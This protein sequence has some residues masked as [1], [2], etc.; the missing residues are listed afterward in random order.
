MKALTRILLTLMVLAL[1]GPA[2]MAHDD[3]DHDHDHDHG[4][5]H[6]DIWPSFHV[7]EGEFEIGGASL[8]ESVTPSVIELHPHV[9][10]FMA[11]LDDAGGFGDS[12]APGLLAPENG[13]PDYPE[14]YLPPGGTL[15]VKWVAP[16][17]EWNETTEAFDTQAGE[18]MYMTVDSVNL[19]V[20]PSS[21]GT[22]VEGVEFTID[23]HGDIHG[24]PDYRLFNGTT[25]SPSAPDDGIYLTQMIIELDDAVGGVFDSEVIYTVYALN[26][27]E[28]E[29]E[30]AAEWVH[31]EFGVEGIGDHDHD[32]VIPEP[33]SIALIGLGGLALARRRRR[34]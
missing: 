12:D 15:T 8:D 16:V 21:T 20:T 3:H 27:T 11:D 19:F 34:A 33:A 4:H 25:S 14:H 2:A 22:T 17:M 5:D 18:S 7:S 32:H 30:H 24:H 13:D 23:S 1:A 10:L 6:V 9:R 29:H 31:E 28:E 26:A